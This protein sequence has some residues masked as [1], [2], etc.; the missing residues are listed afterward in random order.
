MA[1]PAKTNTE[2]L[3]EADDTKRI[4]TNRVNE[5]V[6]LEEQATVIE[7]NTYGNAWIVGSST[8]GLVGTNTGT[9]GGGQQVVGGSG[10]TR[11]TLAVLNPNN[12][13]RERFVDTTFENSGSTTA[14]WAD[15]AGQIAFTNTE[16]AV[17][18]EVALANGTI[19]TA[20]ITATLSSGVITDLAFE[21]TANGGSNWENV[22]HATQHNFTNT[23][24]DLRFRITASGTVVVT[25]LKIQYG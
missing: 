3:F 6:Q 16:V 12:T 19:S 1:T 2:A 18:N 22:T 25:F 17:S 7:D 14:D 8:N 9:D 20:T 4:E 13:F 24:T 11:T 5:K 10:R 23:G 21:L 15:T